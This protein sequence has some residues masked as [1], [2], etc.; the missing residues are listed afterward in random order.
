MIDLYPGVWFGFGAGAGYG[1]TT[2]QLETEKANT[3]KNWE[4][5]GNSYVL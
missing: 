3:L 5:A 2:V 4:H 1:S